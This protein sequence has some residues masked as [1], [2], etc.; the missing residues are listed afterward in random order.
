MTNEEFAQAL[1]RYMESSGG[2]IDFESWLEA[3]FVDH[4]DSSLG[5][6]KPDGKS[7]IK[8]CRIHILMAF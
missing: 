4:S 3:D 2:E 6:R 1:N 8:G 7:L 5:I